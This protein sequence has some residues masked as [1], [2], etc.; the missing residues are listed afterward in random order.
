MAQPEISDAQLLRRVLAKAAPTPAWRVLG[1]R[2][3]ARRRYFVSGHQTWYAVD[4][5]ANAMLNAAHRLGCME[6]VRLVLRLPGM[7]PAAVT[8]NFR[9]QTVTDEAS[10][11]CVSLCWRT[12]DGVCEK[13]PTMIC[14]VDAT[15][16]RPRGR[17]LSLA[18]VLDVT[19][20]TLRMTTAD[21]QRRATCGARWAGCGALTRVDTGSREF[22]VL[23]AQNGVAA[24]LRRAGVV[25]A[26]HRV[27]VD[28]MRQ[29]LFR[30]FTQDAAPTTRAVKA[31]AVKARAVK[32]GAVK[33]EAEAKAGAEE[34][35]EVKEAKATAG[36][37]TLRW[38][39]HGTDAAGVRGICGAD[40]FRLCTARHGRRF[41]HGVYFAT[42]AFAH[43]AMAYAVPRPS[44]A[45]DA[46]CVGYILLCQA[47]VSDIEL[48]RPGQSHSVR[49]GRCG[50]GADALVFPSQLVLWPGF[51]NS[52]VLPRYMITFRWRRPAELA[53]AGDV[54][55]RAAIPRRRR[56]AST[57]AAVQ[58]AVR[59][60]A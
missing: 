45:A 18:S 35:E 20:E 4:A 22:A 7:S 31:G 8:A 43:V 9:L 55:S 19:G 1:R 53:A 41:G 57:G 60:A 33:A 11:L 16:R 54:A 38:V 49:A 26:V 58:H 42:H 34:A 3:W 10:R 15:A 32:A 28:A 25:L 27:E 37:G 40:G 59:A 13:P 47:A 30:V 56:V 29:T 52:Q 50:A 21:R 39:W 2:R 44:S 51:L 5:E 36:G 17:G 48:A 12:A 6:S 46:D 23:F 24:P 14:G